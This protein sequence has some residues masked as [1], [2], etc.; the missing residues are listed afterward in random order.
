MSFSFDVL[1]IGPLVGVG[2]MLAAEWL[3]LSVRYHLTVPRPAETRTASCPAQGRWHRRH[4][5]GMNRA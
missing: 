4:A 2:V 3:Y 1:L 5:V